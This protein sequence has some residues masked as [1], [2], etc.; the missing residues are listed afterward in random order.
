MIGKVDEDARAPYPFCALD[1][2]AN[3]LVSTTGAVLGYA[4]GWK[5]SRESQ[6]FCAGTFCA[7]VR[8]SL[9]GLAALE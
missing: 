3:V 9:F 6:A 7:A 2:P 5:Q 4:A 1:G 8:T